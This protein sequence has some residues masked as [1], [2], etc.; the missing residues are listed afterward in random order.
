M[1]YLEFVLEY[2]NNTK[3]KE[4]RKEEIDRKYKEIY[5]DEKKVACIHRFFGDEKMIKTFPAFLSHN[6]LGK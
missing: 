4:Q 6:K 5:Y 1:R 2:S 3:T